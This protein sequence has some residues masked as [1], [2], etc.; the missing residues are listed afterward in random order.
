VSARWND[1]PPVQAHQLGLRGSQHLPQDNILTVPRN[2]CS[3]S[4]RLFFKGPAPSNLTERREKKRNASYELEFDHSFL[5]YFNQLLKIF[6][7]SIRHGTVKNV[8][9]YIMN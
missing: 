4:L 1:V 6:L 7:K 5:I 3:G 9:V 8:I 2:H